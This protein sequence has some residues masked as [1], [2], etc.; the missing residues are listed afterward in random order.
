[1]SKLVPWILIASGVALIGT[2][3]FV[4]MKKR[5]A[6]RLDR[7]APAATAP[8]RPDISHLEPPE[9]VP[10]PGPGTPAPLETALAVAADLYVELLSGRTRRDPAANASLWRRVGDAFLREGRR[11]RP[12]VPESPAKTLSFYEGI[13]P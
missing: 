12:P 5:S 2:A 8:E 7:T 9:A 1:M 4:M 10:A 6:R 11:R 13:D 3:G